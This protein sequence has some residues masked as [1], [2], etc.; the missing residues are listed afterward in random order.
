MIR[1]A[2]SM[3]VGGVLLFF[4]WLIFGLILSPFWLLI[5]I[6]GALLQAIEWKEAPNVWWE[7]VTIKW[8][9]N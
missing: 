1:N 7:L 6:I 3:M 4:F 2:I 5:I 8:F 9:F